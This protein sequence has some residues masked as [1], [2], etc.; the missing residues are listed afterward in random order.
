MRDAIVKVVLGDMPARLL[1]SH[2]VMLKA[3]AQ[4]QKSSRS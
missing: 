2:D 1:P 3:S 4:V